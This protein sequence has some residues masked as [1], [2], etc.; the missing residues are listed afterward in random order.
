WCAARRIR[1]CRSAGSKRRRNCS[2]RAVSPSFPAGGTRSTTAPRRSWSRSSNPFCRKH[3]TCGSRQYPLR[4][5]PPRTIPPAASVASREYEPF[6]N[7][8]ADKTTEHAPAFRLYPAHAQI[9]YREV[10]V[11][12]VLRA[13]AADPALFDA[14]ERR[15]LRGDDAFVDAD[16]TVL[17]RFRF[18][19]EAE[20]RRH[21]TERL[22]A[23]DQH[24]GRRVG[25][26]RRGIETSPQ[27][28]PPS[29]DHHFRAFTDGIADVLL[30]LLHRFH[31]DQ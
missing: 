7:A 20:H 26:H 15:D 5:R 18:G 17:E 14:A 23:K 10:L 16:H 9:L 30:H 22:F 12:A 4:S 2:E 6:G 25:E 13:L 3:R 28:V 8:D 21:R 31:V 11:D 1:S 27:L 19:L 29:P 24:V